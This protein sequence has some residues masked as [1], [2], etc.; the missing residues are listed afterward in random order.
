[1]DEKKTISMNDISRMAGVSVATV[2]RIINQNGRYSAETER[3]V[4]A[5]IE[6]Y[7]YTPNMVAKGLKTRRSNFVGVIVPDITNE[8]FA[9]IVQELQNGLRAQGYM[10]LV[11]NTGEDEAVERQYMSILGA[12]NLAGLIFVSGNART[13]ESGLQDLPAIYIDRAPEI[14]NKDA[15]VI[16]SDNYGGA[17]LAVQELYEK[18]CRRIACLNYSKVVSTYSFRHSGY[19]DQLSLYGLPA[20]EDLHLKVDE[21]SFH[22]G[23]QAVDRALRE[24]RQFD[25]IFCTTD[26]LAL[27]AVTALEEN[28]LRVPEDVKVVGFDDISM[29]SLT[30]KPLTTIHQQTDVLGR[31]AADEILRLINGAPDRAQRIQIGVSLI[32][33]QTT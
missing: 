12:V 27:G 17:R 29:A 31:T 1:M 24:G 3:R 21:I 10:A 26:W 16:E 28:G 14:G 4:R 13:V 32:R 30:A 9:Q 5:I 8:F 20:A 33:R 15:L 11:C 6:K 2:S 19:Q 7:H 23:R 22:A 18:G 25:G